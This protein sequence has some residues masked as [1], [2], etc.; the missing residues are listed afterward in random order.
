MQRRPS[1]EVL[2]PMRST[3]ESLLQMP[4][5]TERPAVKSR[6]FRKAS[7]LAPSL[8]ASLWQTLQ[9]RGAYPLM[10]SGAERPHG[11]GDSPLELETASGHC[12]AT[13][14]ERHEDSPAR[15][16]PS[17][18]GLLSMRS[19][20]GSLLQVLNTTDR[21]ALMS[22]KSNKACLWQRWHVKGWYQLMKSGAEKLH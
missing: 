20:E 21:F 17:E 12:H 16:F 22:W 2:V 10:N 6:R 4:K 9:V 7:A 5:T 8:Q 13:E 14:D 1:E 19:V 11:W 3:E 15:G 18:E